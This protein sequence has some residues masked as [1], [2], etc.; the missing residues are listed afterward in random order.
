[1]PLFKK[2]GG[3]SMQSS[4]VHSSSEI[5]PGTCWKFLSRAQPSSCPGV[6][7][8]GSWLCSLPSGSLTKSQSS[9]WLREYSGLL[10]L[11]PSH[12]SFSVKGSVCVR[13]CARAAESFSQLAPCQPNVGGLTASFHRVRSLCLPTQVVSVYAGIIL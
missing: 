3:I 2:G 10:V 5:Q 4:L 11:P 8:P 6:I 9:R 13:V 1:M 7:H 12:P